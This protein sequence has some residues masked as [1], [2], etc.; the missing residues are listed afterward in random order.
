MQ[1]TTATNELLLKSRETILKLQTELKCETSD[2][3]NLM[4][5][6]TE[7]KRNKTSESN[8][9]IELQVQ[10]NK[11]IN[12]LLSKIEM[13]QNQSAQVN[14][15]IVQRDGLESHVNTLEG[16]VH[17]LTGRV[18]E[19]TT[20]LN[21]SHSRVQIL[22]REN[23]GLLNSQ[24]DMDQHII[25]LERQVDELVE[26]N[27]QLQQHDTTQQSISEQQYNTIKEQ[28]ELAAN[29]QVDALKKQYDNKL[30]SQK[31]LISSQQQQLEALSI[32]TTHK[33]KELDTVRKENSKLTGHLHDVTESMSN[34]W[35]KQQDQYQLLWSD[36]LSQCDKRIDQLLI[37]EKSMNEYIV[38]SKLRHVETT[39]QI[40]AHITEINVLNDKIND[41]NKYSQQKEYEFEQYRV[42]QKSQILNEI[43]NLHIKFNETVVAMQLERQLAATQA[44]KPSSHA[45]PY[46]TVGSDTIN[47]HTNSD[48][49][50]SATDTTAA[51]HHTHQSTNGINAED[52]ER[53]IAKHLSAF[54]TFT[55]QTNTKLNTIIDEPVNGSTS[56][57]TTQPIDD[58][59]KSIEHNNNTGSNVADEKL[60]ESPRT[61]LIDGSTLKAVT[62]ALQY[63]IE[64]RY[65]QQ[66]SDKLNLLQQQHT[67]ELN[68]YQ[69]QI[70]DLRC[71]LTAATTNTN[72]TTNYTQQIDSLQQQLH[73]I[74]QLYHNE[75]NQLHSIKQAHSHCGTTINN[76]ISTIDTLTSQLQQQSKLSVHTPAIESKLNKYKQK[77]QSDTVLIRKLQDK[78]NLLKHA[79]LQYKSSKHKQSNINTGDNQILFDQLKHEMSLRQQAESEA[80]KYT[81]LYRNTV[82][83]QITTGMT[84]NHKQKLVELID[85]T[86]NFTP[87]NT[88]TINKTT[89]KL[90]CTSQSIIG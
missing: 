27:T 31:N 72:E 34:E 41:L 57:N 70:N 29:A 46:D 80:N 18:H 52:M 60:H 82:I 89:P 36:K 86:N 47:N 11:Q 26:L 8:K 75:S 56:N 19:L 88:T 38:H 48:H 84:L 45:Q 61:E 5:E 35:N 68:V 16:T 6:L 14:E 79:I 7:S 66:H 58:T 28:L 49:T 62:D 39:A 69:Q 25:S 10:H 13:Y 73:S 23:V 1:C 63:Q 22:E 90:D 40:Q 71:Q 53:I 87:L 81:L 20:Q 74:Q 59:I 83:N 78:I 17:E 65:I 54:S 33:I 50:V 42:E 24:K 43:E 15:L 12:E 9:L 76:H 37:N 55:Q 3:I 4:N 51:P 67:T 32:A 30:E 64:S 77:I 21:A 44:S 2:K 85:H